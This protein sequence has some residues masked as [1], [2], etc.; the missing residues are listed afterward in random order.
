MKK[1]YLNFTFV[2]LLLFSSVIG[3]LLQ[4]QSNSNGN[5]TQLAADD[6][7]VIDLDSQHPTLSQLSKEVIIFSEQTASRQQEILAN[8]DRYRLLP[9][10]SVELNNTG[11]GTDK[12]GI[13]ER[14]AIKDH[15]SPVQ[16]AVTGLKDV[17][18]TMIINLLINS[19]GVN[20]EYGVQL[21]AIE[22]N[23][24]SKFVD[25]MSQVK[26]HNG[27]TSIEVD[28]TYSKIDLIASGISLDMLM[29]NLKT[30]LKDGK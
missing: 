5:S 16:F 29:D 25:R 19:H 11:V 1:I 18:G 2:A 24:V 30:S 9:N 13:K 21:V 15:G 7:A 12:Y 22:N 10:G 3:N 8:P 6:P 27:I 20:D 4:A 23:S 14:K 26:G 17:K 28:P